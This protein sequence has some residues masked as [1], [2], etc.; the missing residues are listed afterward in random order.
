MNFEI[1]T[2]VVTSELGKIDECIINL[3]SMLSNIESDISSGW[4]SETAR[5]V[6]TPAI[7][8]IKSSIDAMQKSVENVRSNVSQYITNT[9]EADTAGSINSAE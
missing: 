3:R 6:V 1:N 5:T 8:D 7:D 2:G 4:N 9:E